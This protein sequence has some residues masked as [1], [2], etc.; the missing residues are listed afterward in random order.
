M[1][2]A[3]HWKILAVQTASELQQTL[4][5]GSK[6]VR[7]EEDDTSP[8]ATGFNEFLAVELLHRGISVS[9]DVGDKVV[10]VKVEVVDHQSGPPK[11]PFAGTFL[12][13]VSG[14]AVWLDEAQPLTV[15]ADAVLPIAIAGGG[16]I[17]AKRDLLPPATATEVIVSTSV[18]E[19]GYRTA[20]KTDVFYIRTENSDEYYPVAA[21]QNI[22]VSGS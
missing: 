20:G 9:P 10:K 2:S 21:G 8:F 22:P 11:D 7:L 5:P 6:A 18:Y 3:S 17:D 12:G 15:T 14:L 4:P 16:V 19:R 1:F 13:V